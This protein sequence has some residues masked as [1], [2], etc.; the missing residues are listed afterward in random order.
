MP[1]YMALY[2]ILAELSTFFALVRLHRI[3]GVCAIVWRR[4]E[5]SFS[6]QIWCWMLYANV[7]SFMLMSLLVFLSRHSSPLLYAIFFIH[8]NQA[9]QTKK[10]KVNGNG[11]VRHRWGGMWGGGERVEEMELEIEQVGTTFCCIRNILIS[12]VS[13]ALLR[14][15][16]WRTVNK[17]F[18]RTQR[19]TFAGNESDDRRGT[20]ANHLPGLN[21]LSN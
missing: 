3:D 6:M 18:A 8:I 9:T 20:L 13:I 16:T 5:R 7:M 15:G 19:K 14:Y 12:K 4:L 17:S 10:Q 1:C 2:N 11:R 21:I